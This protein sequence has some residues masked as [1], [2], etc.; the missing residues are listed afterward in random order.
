MP[1]PEDEGDDEGTA[2]AAD[3]ELA[4]EL[5]KTTLQIYSEAVERLL[6][7]VARRLASGIDQ[8]GWA[9][10]KLAEQV[11]LRNQAQAVVT[12]L[13]ADS[14]AVIEAALTGAYT[15]GAAEVGTGFAT[16]NQRGLDALIRETVTAVESTH[17]RILRS[18]GD[19]YRQTI[20]EAALPGVVTGTQTTRQ[21]AQAALNRFANQG[22]TG[23]TDAAGRNWQLDSYVEMATR[24]GAGRAQVAGGLDRLVDQGKDLV[25]VSNAPQECSKCRPWEGRILSISGDRVG[26]RVD[27]RRVVA[28]VATARGDGLLHANCR[29]VLGA[30]VEGLTKPMTHTADPEGDAARQE[31]R[32]L[33][34]GVRQWK[35]REA[36]AMSD[37][38]RAQA[39]AKVREWQAALKQ[40]VDGNGLKRQRH[41]ETVGGYGR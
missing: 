13:A 31:Q 30:Y 17:F 25:I 9:E 38:E 32:R 4:A 37:G 28:S 20:T 3:P 40:H 23:F 1:A 22:V 18:V 21:A 16:T 15:K 24:T 11:A 14:P 27:G 41:R 12:Q 36:V 34:R 35:R 39:R 2:P 19:I 5:A 29:H 33:E 26:E 7:I 6:G 8:P 10:T